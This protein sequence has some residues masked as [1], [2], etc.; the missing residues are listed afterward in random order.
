MFFFPFQS[1]EN[2]TYY[3]YVP[4]KLIL[5]WKQ[6]LKYFRNTNTPT[7]FSFMLHI[8]TGKAATISSDHQKNM[9]PLLLEV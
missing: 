3:N 7:L 8:A 9:T 2:K 6:L 1:S 5:L 4:D